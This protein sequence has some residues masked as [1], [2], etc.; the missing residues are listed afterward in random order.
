MTLLPRHFVIYRFRLFAGVRETKHL[1][2]SMEDYDDDRC[3]LCGISQSSASNITD[4]VFSLNLYF[5]P[6]LFI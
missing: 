2:V 3:A 6:S 5:N 1:I 4:E